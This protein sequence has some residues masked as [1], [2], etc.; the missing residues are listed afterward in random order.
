MQ[1]PRSIQST[2]PFTPRNSKDRTGT[3]RS[4]NVVALDTGFY[5]QPFSNPNHETLMKQWALQG[6]QWFSCS[7]GQMPSRAVQ[8]GYSRAGEPLYIAR[9][10]SPGNTHCLGIFHP[11]SGQCYFC[12]RG[13][14]YRSS[15]YDILCQM[16]KLKNRAT[17]IT[18]PV[19]SE[20]A[21]FGD[22]MKVMTLRSPLKFSNYNRK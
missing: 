14:E 15:T 20:T 17:A 21:T 9:A 11:S 2:R 8:R 13:R 18:T 1:R 16:P 19:T 3:A 10:M 5:P 22:T 12:W 7:D 6:Y 4:Y